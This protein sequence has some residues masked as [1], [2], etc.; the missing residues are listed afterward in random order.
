MSLVTQERI[1]IDAPPERVWPVMA[2][3]E[4][5]NEWTPSI[6]S[7][8]LLG[9]PMGPGARALVRQPKLPPV[10]WR[11]TSWDPG[12]SFEWE[13]RSPGSH[14]VGFHR[15]EPR[16]QGSLATLGVIQSG[17]V[18][19]L[20]GKMIAGLTRSYVAMEAAGLK[21]RAEARD[22]VSP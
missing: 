8:Q 3:V 13:A 22:R 2:D 16:G 10:V 1:E 4:R 6:T 5:W 7:I 20:V 19:W 21:K 17:P 18:G 15:V 11:V 14:V 12:R 9:G